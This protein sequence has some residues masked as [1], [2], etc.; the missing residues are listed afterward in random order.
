MV[1][2]YIYY[3]A[4]VTISFL[5]PSERG[6]H[7]FEISATTVVLIVASVRIDCQVDKKEDQFSWT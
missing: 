7:T 6:L 4:A 3:Q 1:E 5:Q 2:F